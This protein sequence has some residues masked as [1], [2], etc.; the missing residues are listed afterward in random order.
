MAGRCAC[1]A[2]LICARDC[3]PSGCCNAS[4]GPV[5]KKLIGM[6][7]QSEETNC[8][9]RSHLIIALEW[10]ER[11]HSRQGRR[12]SDPLKRL[13]VGDDVNVVHGVDGVE[14]LDEAFFVVRLSEPGGVVEK[15]ERRSV[16]RVMSLEV[17]QDHLVNVFGLGWVGARVAHRAASAV[18]V[19]PHHHGNFPHSRVALGRARWNHAV[20]E[21]F[22]VE[23][24]RPAGWTV[25]VHRHR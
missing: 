7:S 19:L 1:I 3:R 23:S 10:L 5:V 18:Q 4:D 20:V 8:A 2:R 13:P 6:L 9:V 16:R 21:E 22:V 17:L 11:I 15:A 25:L 12:I 14:E 24:V